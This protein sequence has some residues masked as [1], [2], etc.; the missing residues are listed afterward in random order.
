VYF[1]GGGF[2]VGDLD[3]HHSHTVRYANRSQVVVVNV[4]YRL[5]PEYPFPQGLDDCIAATRWADGHRTRL[6][7][8]NRPLAVGGDSAGGNFAAVTAIDSRDRGLKLAAQLLVYPVTDMTALGDPDIRTAYFGGHYAQQSKDPRAS[9]ILANLTGVAP[10]LLAVGDHDFLYDDNVAYVA[11]LRAAGVP[12]ILREYPDLNHGFCS[13]A[14]ISKAS[15]AA[16]EQICDDLREMIA[17]A[18]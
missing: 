1:H 10:A 11:A 3:S 9:P 15:N 17:E 7:G 5:A 14:G 4:D 8:A 16:A 2:V 18:A 12:L 13:T 6:G